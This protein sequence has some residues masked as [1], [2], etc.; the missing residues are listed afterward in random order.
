[1]SRRV[2]ILVAVALATTGCGVGSTG[3]TS[4]VSTDPERG[5]AAAGLSATCGSN[6]FDSLPPDVST[7]PAFTAWDDLDLAG[8][9]AELLGFVEAYDWFV[10]EETASARSLY[11]LPR[12]PEGSRTL[13]AYASLELRDGRWKPVGWGDCRIELGADGWGNAR[14]EMDR[15][16]SP[17]PSATTFTVLATEVNCAGGGPP[18]DRD[19]R[20]VVVD[21]SEKAVAVLILVEPVQGAVTCQGNPDFPFEVELPSA[22][23]DRE[24]LDASGYPFEARWPTDRD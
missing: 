18:T 13:A 3:A 9:R 21:E 22:I 14:F 8:T 6:R 2:V 10:T 12:S 16:S 15:S 4:S 19:V 1:M 7:L 20:A 17:D 24:V 5:F 23:G 11:G